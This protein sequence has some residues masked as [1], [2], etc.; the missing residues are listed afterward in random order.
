MTN[1]LRNEE[2]NYIVIKIVSIV[3]CKRQTQCLFEFRKTKSK[4][5]FQSVWNKMFGALALAFLSSNPP[6][7]TIRS[8]SFCM[9]CRKFGRNYPDSV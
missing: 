1:S 3:T 9:K 7:E 2:G 5:R 6:D 4:I 8:T